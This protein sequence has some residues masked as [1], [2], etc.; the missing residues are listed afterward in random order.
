MPFKSTQRIHTLLQDELNIDYDLVNAVLGDND[1]EY[2]TRAL[3]NLL[4]IRNRA[5]FL[6]EIRNNG[7][8][9]Q[10]YETV[11]RS[12]KLAV[13]GSLKT[14]KLEI[15]QVINPEYFESNSEQDLYQA[16]QKLAPISQEAKRESNYQL[17]IDGLLEI[18]P[19]ISNFFDGE[20]SV[21]VMA[22][23]EKIKTNR[24][25]LLGLLRNYS[26]VLADFGA[27]VK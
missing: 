16:L 3:T 26:R 11:N 7:L 22:E 6:Q 9:S 4:D 23:D 17:L 24:L 15:N 18:N 25:N 27:I 12:T 21:L 2:I 14:D 1:S 10:I 5:L 13:K 19:I 8:L 20:N